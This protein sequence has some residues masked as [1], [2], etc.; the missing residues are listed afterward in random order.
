MLTRALAA[1]ESTFV[2]LAVNRTRAIVL[3]GLLPL[4]A[5]ALLLPILPIPKPAIQD[6]FSYLLAADTFASGR[7]V[8][9]TPALAEHFETPQVL[10]RPVYASKYPPFSG[11]VMAAAQ[12]LTGQPWF[13]VWLGMGVLCATICWA[14]QGWLPPVWALAASLIAAL[15]IGIVSYWTEGYWGGTWTAVGGALLIGAAP[16]LIERR[17]VST[18]LAF[19]VGLVVLAN[20]RP[21]EGLVFAGV[22]SGWLI[23]EWMRNRAEAGE[24]FRRA[25]L[26][27]V[28][29]L[30]PVAAWMAYYNFRVTGN[31]FELPYVAHDRQYATRPPLLFFNRERAAPHYSSAFLQDFW[32]AD[33]DEKQQAQHQILQTHVWDLAILWGFLIGWPLTAC[34]VL[35]ARPLWR[36]PIARRAIVLGALAYIGPALDTRAFPHYAAAGAV[37]VFIVAACALRAMRKTW[38]GADGAYLMWAGLLVFALPTAVGLLTP[39]NRCLIGSMKY[40]DAEHVSLE[41]RVAREP[42]RHLMLVRYGPA[43]MDAVHHHKNYE[44]LVYNHADI[45]GSKVIWARSLGREKDDEL[46]R[47]YPNREVWIVEEDTGVTLSRVGA[48]ESRT[49]ALRPE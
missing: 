7:L 14:I 33:H 31:A 28:A 1:V 43:A 25:V 29:L 16:R 36:D 19:G 35:V 10:M 45:D 34:V 38:P 22:C 30:I 42:G 9:P 15:H 26:P 24:I 13:G 3:A 4:I 27:I 44:E 47:H 39:E 12:K 21:F 20:T 49:V 17:T 6:E 32:Q 48:P 37:L 11:L 5:R 8:N 40:L 23:W 46:I 18:A 2:R 41:E